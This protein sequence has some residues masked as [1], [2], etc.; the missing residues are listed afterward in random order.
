MSLWPAELPVLE[1]GDAV[2]VRNRVTGWR[3]VRRWFAAFV[4][5]VTSTQTGEDDTFA[6]HVAKVFGVV[7]VWRDGGF[8]V[9]DYILY[10]ALGKEGYVKR[11]LRAAYENGHTDVMIYRHPKVGRKQRIALHAGMLRLRGRK[12]G[13]LKIAAHGAD[14]GLTK[15]WNACGGP[16]EVR[17]FRRF[18]RMEKYPICSWAESY[19]MRTWAKLPYK[20]PPEIAS[21]DDL[22]DECEESWDRVFVFINK[23]D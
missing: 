7:K 19:L 23:E 11:G 9:V 22:H 6:G 16:G 3:T 1:I 18:A 21:P 20:T 10:E 17:L 12:Y 4:V 15:F 8:R 5:R 13:K 2:F 14:Y